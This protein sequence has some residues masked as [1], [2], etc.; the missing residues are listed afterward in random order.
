MFPIQFYKVKNLYSKAQYVYIQARTPIDEFWLCSQSNK[1]SNSHLI[2]LYN[3][4][5]YTY[6][7]NY[8]VLEN[9]DENEPYDWTINSPTIR[10]N[11]R[12][13]LAWT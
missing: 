1:I 10:G 7:R 5:T 12:D 13:A 4:N 3:I 11:T 9:E 6:I 8:I 2:P